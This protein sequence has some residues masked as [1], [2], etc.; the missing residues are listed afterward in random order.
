M[1]VAA[2]AVRALDYTFQL[3]QG[4]FG[5]SGQTTLT[6]P[7]GLRSQLHIEFA[8]L[9]TT[10]TLH[11]HIYGVT[12]DHMNAISKAGLVW[13]SRRNLIQVRAGDTI[14]G[15][16]TIFAGII[17][18]A[19]PDMRA[20]PET[21]LYVFATPTSTLQLAP[22]K[23]VSFG[24]P[25][26]ASTALGAILAPADVALENNDVPGV[27]SAPYFPGD[28]WSQARSAVQALRCH[29]FY[30]G[31]ANTL[32]IWPKNGARSGTP[33][34][35]SPATGL[36]GYP[37]FQSN[38]V[39]FRVLFDPAIM[40]FTGSPG[41]LVNMQSGLTA[42]DGTLKILS[43]DFDL[44]AQTIDGPWEMTVTAIPYNQST[45]A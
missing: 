33:T 22:A 19:Y 7:S 43:V 10:G 28:T 44:A 30:D 25:T 41:R 14:S 26:D 12:L 34:V 36:I 27:L 17:Q 42:A 24:G 9:P 38:Q 16:T 35:I 3:G 39:I 8:T 31:V 45:G 13:G 23:P 37:S 40:P 6:L 2:Y 18:E 1:T 32:A 21:P 5:A 4:S 20:Q 11:A 15:M 29:A